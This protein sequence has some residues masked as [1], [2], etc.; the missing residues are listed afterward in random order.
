M[1]AAAPL[2]PLVGPILAMIGG[3]VLAMGSFATWVTI[4]EAPVGSEVGTEGGE[5]WITIVLGL[6][7]LT[8]GALA[9]GNPQ[10]LWAWA[11]IIVGGIGFAV[12]IWE[13]VN[14]KD[15][16]VHALEP[17]LPPKPGISVEEKRR[18]IEESIEQSG[19]GVAAGIGLYFVLIG[20]GGGGGARGP[21][22]RSR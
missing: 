16:A 21:Q 2:R 10:R 19:V 17:F 13:I 9:L 18:I 1:N 6:V 14:V 22:T 8:I 12:G 15:L 7:L 5:S 11:C 3:V 4:A 20:G